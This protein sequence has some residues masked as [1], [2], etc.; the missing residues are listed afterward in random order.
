MTTGTLPKHLAACLDDDTLD[1]AKQ[2]ICGGESGDRIRGTWSR[3]RLAN[4]QDA[5]DADEC[6]VA[7]W[8]SRETSN[9]E[10]TWLKSSEIKLKQSFAIVEQY[11]GTELLGERYRP[12]PFPFRRRGRRYKMI[13]YQRGKLSDESTKK[14]R[15]WKS[16]RPISSPLTA[17]Q[18][19]YIIAP[20]F[21]EDDYE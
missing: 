3:L 8:Y 17:E 14:N 6:Q 4:R 21:G 9:G 1:V 10:R 15:G 11:P 12:P 20:A 16:F 13:R 19:S 18:E 5:K 2:S 7:N